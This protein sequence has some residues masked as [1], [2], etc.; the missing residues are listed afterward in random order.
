MGL[1]AEVCQSSHS[2]KSSIKMSRFF[3]E[4]RVI[5]VS[6]NKVSNWIKDFFEKLPLEGAA[7]HKV[8]SKIERTVFR[9]KIKKNLML[10]L[11]RLV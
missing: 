4:I 3:K 5:P 11:L 1:L 8:V 10:Y 7:N 6:I 2:P 9:K